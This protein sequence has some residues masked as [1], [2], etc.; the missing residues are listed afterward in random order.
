MGPRRVRAYWP[1]F[2]RRLFH[3][4][5]SRTTRLP[6]FRPTPE[7]ID[8]VDRVIGWASNF[9]PKDRRIYLARLASIPWRI[10]EANERISRQQAHK[11]LVDCFHK[12][13]ESEIDRL[14][15]RQKNRHFFVTMAEMSAR[16]RR[17]GA[18]SSKSRSKGTDVKAASD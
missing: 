1:E 12:I 13:A 11:R 18:S 15:N 3:D 6:R 10:I 7:D 16:R 9:N 4:E 2:Q 5:I 17:T 14:T 8:G